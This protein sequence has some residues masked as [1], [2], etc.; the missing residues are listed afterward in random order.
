MSRL[1]KFLPISGS[2]NKWESGELFYVRVQ[3]EL[4]CFSRPEFKTGRVSSIVPSHS[5]ANGILSAFLSHHGVSYSIKQIGLLFYP[6]LTNITT[7][8]VNNFSI[9]G[10]AS[11]DVDH[12]RTQINT[13]AL[14]DVDY[15]MSF[16]VVSN[17]PPEVL[18]YSNM[19]N[20]RLPLIKPGEDDLAR[21][22]GVWSRMPYLGLREYVGHVKRINS[23]EIKSL[24]G[25]FVTHDDGM[26]SVD[27]STDLG[28]TFFGTDYESNKNYFIPIKVDRGVVRYPSWKEVTDHN[29]VL[30]FG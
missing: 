5:A 16:R 3:G 23:E 28:I 2:N 29:I 14:C 10:T 7:N 24:D 20:S 21:V 22:G 18:K 1:N 15:W 27:F 25:D 9:G 30:D 26:K 17:S 12:R 8:E 19:F 4:A 11:I 13:Q 6:Q